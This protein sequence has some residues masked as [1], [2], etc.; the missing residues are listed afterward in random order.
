M[1]RGYS[2][3][4]RLEASEGGGIAVL[5][6]D[7]GKAV[8]AA[9]RLRIRVAKKDLVLPAYLNW[10]IRQRDVQVVLDRVVCHYVFFVV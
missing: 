9:P 6:E 3:R 7:P 2:F 1:Q 8:V 10:Y 4:S 5:L